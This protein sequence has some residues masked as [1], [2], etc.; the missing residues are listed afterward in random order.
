MRFIAR[1]LLCA[2]SVL[3]AAGCNLAADRQYMNEGAGVE[4]DYAGLPEATARQQV[5]INEICQQAGY[6]RQELADAGPSCMDRSGWDAFVLAGINDINRRCDGYLTWLDAKRRDRAPIQKEFLAV[7]GATDAILAASGASSGT[8]AIVSAALALAGATYDNWNSRLLL[9][10]NQSTVQEVV[11]SRQTQ[12]MEQLNEQ[13]KGRHVSSRAAAIYLLRNYLRLC[14]PTTIETDINTSITLVQRGNPMDAK[15]NPLVK[16][17]VAAVPLT[18][19]QRA[20]QQQQRNRLPFNKDFDAIIIDYKPQQYPPS[21]VSRIL[22][23]LCVPE[24]ERRKPGAVTKNLIKIYE[25]TDDGVN[26]AAPDGKIDDR[27]A[28]RI[29]FPDGPSVPCS[30]N[31]PQN[32]YERTTY[33]DAD[34]VADLIKELNEKSSVGGSIDEKAPLSKARDKIKDLRTKLDSK[35][36]LH[37]PSAL[38]GQMTQDLDKAMFDFKQ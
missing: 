19:R 26:G 25:Q 1:A 27:E 29:L 24:T 22:A 3:L 11:Y 34:K 37:L 16:T 2:S 8:L 35:L 31:G 20:N 9:A 14:M 6:P 5:Y 33:T 7:A 36:D 32:Y 23:A 30:D 10:V 18:A 17:T 12:F 15:T 21:Y 38:S 13:F 4:L 28:G